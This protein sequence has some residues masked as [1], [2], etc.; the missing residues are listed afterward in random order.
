MTNTS[1]NH[2]YDDSDY[3]SDLK[4]DSSNAVYV[5]CPRSVQIEFGLNISGHKER[6]NLK[7]ENIVVSKFGIE[8]ARSSSWSNFNQNHV[9]LLLH[10]V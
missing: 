6:A 3:S 4:F 1:I 9:M 8:N 5:Y 10:Y 2:G 7:A